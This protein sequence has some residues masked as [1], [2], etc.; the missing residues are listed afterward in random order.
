MIDRGGRHLPIRADFVGKNVPTSKTELIDI[1]FE[2]LGAEE[3]AVYIV[4]KTK[5]KEI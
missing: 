4:K 3:D 1:R 2:E 5:T